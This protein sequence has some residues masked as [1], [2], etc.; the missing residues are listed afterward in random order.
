[1][2][3]GNDCAV[4]EREL[5]LPKSLIAMSLPNWARTCF[6]LPPA[7]AKWLTEIKRQSRYPS[8]IVMP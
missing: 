7:P 8:G 5:T 1:M 3:R 4:R 2:Q 6:N